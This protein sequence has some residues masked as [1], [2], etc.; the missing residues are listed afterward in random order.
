M[1]FTQFLIEQQFQL[2]EKRNLNHKIWEDTDMHEDVKKALIDIAEAFVEFVDSKDLK[3]DDVTMTGSLA[4]YTWHD[5]SDIDLH[6]MADMRKIECKETAQAFFDAKKA[7]WNMEHDI[8]IKGFP[9]ELYVQDMEE[10]HVSSGVYS[11]EYDKWLVKPKKSHPS[12][13][14]SYVIAKADKWKKMIDDLIKNK[15]NSKTTIDRLK[16]RLREMRKMGLDRDGEYSVENLA[17]KILRN[18][19]YIEKLYDYARDMQDAEL[20][21]K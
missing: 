1:N 3:V 8:R 16:K 10:D 6:I 5:Q 17:F 20:S 18:D 2:E 12:I 11:L 4:N 7:L 21:L 14:D 13:D 9:V 15:T 19:G